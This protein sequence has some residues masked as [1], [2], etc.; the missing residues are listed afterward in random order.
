V[1]GQTDRRLTSLQPFLC[2][3]NKRPLRAT[4]LAP[5]LCISMPSGVSSLRIGTTL[6]S[7]LNQ[8][9]FLYRQPLELETH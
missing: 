3:C 2:I 9:Q 4:V 8:W 1:N 5:E 7:L 6:A